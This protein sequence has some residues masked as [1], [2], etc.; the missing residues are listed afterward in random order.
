MTLFW[1][2]LKWTA[3]SLACMGFYMLGFCKGYNQQ[4]RDEEDAKHFSIGL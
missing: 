1:I 3:L 2:V 4:L